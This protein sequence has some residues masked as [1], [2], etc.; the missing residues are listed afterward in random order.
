[1]LRRKKGCDCVD[2]PSK[3]TRGVSVFVYNIKLIDIQP[4]QSW[5]KLKALSLA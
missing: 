4:R 1:V 2:R 3:Y 5:I